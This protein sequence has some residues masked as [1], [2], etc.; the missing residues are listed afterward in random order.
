MPN[1]YTDRAVESLIINKMTQAQY[2]ALPEKSDTELYL[3][4]GGES[5]MFAE[6]MIVMPEAS[7]AYLNRIVQFIGNSTMTYI[8]GYFYRCV[9]QGGTYIW[10]KINVQANQGGGGSGQEIQFDDLP[11]AT[12]ENIGQILQYVGIDIPKVESSATISQTVGSGIT[13]L[14]INVRTFESAEHP[15]ADKVVDF[16]CSNTIQTN[17]TVSDAGRGFTVTILDQNQIINAFVDA[18]YGDNL[19]NVMYGGVNYYP[20]GMTN[21]RYKMWIED[22][23]GQHYVDIYDGTFDIQEPDPLPEESYVIASWN[24]FVIGSEIWQKNNTEVNLENYG[25]THSG[26]VNTGDTLEVVYSAATPEYKKGYFYINQPEWS[27]PSATISQTVGSGL[28]DLSVDVEKFVETEQPSGSETARFEYSSSGVTVTPTSGSNY[29]LSVEIIDATTFW[30]KAEEEFSHWGEGTLQSVQVWYS[31][32]SEFKLQVYNETPGGGGYNYTWHPMSDA[33]NCGLSFSG[34]AS[35]NYFAV[36]TNIIAIPVTS[37]WK[38]NNNNINIQDYGISYTGVPTNGDTLTVVY[39]EGVPSYSWNQINVQP[40]SEGGSGIVWKTKMDIPTGITEWVYPQYNFGIVPD[41]KYELYTQMKVTTEQ[42]VVS[43]V[44]Y[45]WFIE[46]TTSDGQRSYNAHVAYVLDGNYSSDANYAISEYTPIVNNLFW[47][48]NSG[49]LIL[50]STDWIAWAADLPSYYPDYSAEDGIGILKASSLKNTYT[51]EEYVGTGKYFV[52]HQDTTGLI[53]INGNFYQ[54]KFINFPSQS[55]FGTTFYLD[56]DY[57]Y[58]RISPATVPYKDRP[59]PNVDY[60]HISFISNNGDCFDAKINF[61]YSKYKLEII[62]ATGMFTNVQ[63]GYDSNSWEHNL[64]LKKPTGISASGFAA[65]GGGNSQ[66]IYINVYSQ[67]IGEFTPIEALYVGSTVTKDNFGTI[68]QY[69]GDTDA[70]YTNGYFYKATGT[71]VSVPESITCQENSGYG[72]NITCTDL[73]GLIEYIATN[74]GYPETTIRNWFIWGYGTWYYYPENS[75]AEKWYW[76]QTAYFP[77]SAMI[78]FF[79]F[80]QTPENNISWNMVNYQESREEIQNG[81]WEQVNVQPGDA[82]NTVPDVTTTITNT[83]WSGDPGNAGFI[84]F[85]TEKR[86]PEVGDYLCNNNGKPIQGIIMKYEDLMVPY[87]GWLQIASYDEN[88][89]TATMTAGGILVRNVVDLSPFTINYEDV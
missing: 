88:S 54:T 32:T 74:Y 1:T 63:F 42:G 4:D 14:S 16:V 79:S 24:D 82:N 29:G 71:K 41:G 85:L 20:D 36:T 57:E 34:T 5:S 49:E 37:N 62:E 80:D 27:D 33:A 89:D 7:E 55:R 22:S 46:L 65:V 10:K 39:T 3:I 78:N 58:F 17:I 38:K 6:Q 59:Y 35:N 70:N 75:D 8:T 53:N 30:A 13:D 50:G 47:T 45:K 68:L 43:Y 67:N 77:D 40:A 11:E 12:S 25:I 83:V 23:E 69:T 64:Y 81:H 26:T 44:T 21:V 15:N 9:L 19:K 2:D 72:I 87:T 61:S 48:N 66:Q 28:T 51:G 18:G 73:T 60:V 76:D 31:D 84:N 56:N 52:G 86:H